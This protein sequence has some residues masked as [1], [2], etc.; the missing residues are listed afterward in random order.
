MIFEFDENFT[1]RYI[2]LILFK[3]MIKYLMRKIWNSHTEIFN[4]HKSIKLR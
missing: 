1:S 2:L 4:N 3:N